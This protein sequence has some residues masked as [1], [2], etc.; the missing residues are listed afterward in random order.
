MALGGA[1]NSAPTTEKPAWGRVLICG[2]IDWANLGRS[3]KAG[4]SAAKAESEFPDILQPCILRS[5]ANIRAVSIHTSHSACHAVVLDIYGTAFLFGRNA[6][7]CLGLPSS[8][9]AITSEQTPRR[10]RPVQC[11][12]SKNSIKFINAACG[13]AHTLL[14]DDAGDLWTAGI[15]TLGQC[16]HPPR[17]E[18]T[19]FKKVSGP[20]LKTTPPDKVVA[21]SAGITFSIV[22]TESGK[23]YSFGSAEMGQLGNGRTGEHISTGNKT[24]FDV[25]HEPIRIKAFEGKKIVQIASGQQHSIALA[26]D[27]NVYVWGTGGYCRTGLGNPKDHL[28]PVPVPK[29]SQ[30]LVLRGEQVM[31]GPTSSVVVDRQ[32]IYW[33]AGKWKT[34][35]DGSSGQPY[36]NFRLLQDIMGCRILGGACGGVTHF[37]FTPS[38]DGCVMTIGWGQGAN[39]CELGL[40]DGQPKSA[41]KPV[42][43]TTLKGIDVFQIAA[44]AHTSF[45]LA[46]PNQALSDLDRYPEVEPSEDCQVCR[47]NEGDGSDLLECEKC[48]NPYHLHCLDPPLS[49]V[50]D[51]EWFCAECEADSDSRGVNS[52]DSIDSESQS[53]A[54]RKRGRPRK[55]VNVSEDE[56]EDE[57]DEDGDEDEEPANKKYRKQ[58]KGNK[59]RR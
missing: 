38:E 49:T 36:S 27:G 10:L 44:G 26:E 5:L 22:L 9:S 59:R 35:G 34:S 43:I 21:A 37:C 13:R 4:A 47:K 20:W 50:P 29:F 57:E 53:S 39:N 33:L 2:G 24:A 18:V 17:P 56:E 41:T 23:V 46:R 55:N 54:P 31:A 42:E 28:V 16:G 25:E 48:E 15:N 7:S 3:R 19:S 14:I 52:T 12:A 58:V 30:E 32:G 40:G 51:G 6:S 11:G 1:T 8:T 45:F